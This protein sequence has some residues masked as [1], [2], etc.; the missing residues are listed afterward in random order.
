MG[1]N[2]DPFSKKII[3]ILKKKFKFLSIYLSTHSK[4]KPNKKILNW[5][6]DLIICFRSHFILNAMFIKKAKIGAIN[7]HPGPPQ[8]RGIGCINFALNNLENYY[9]ATAHLIEKK[10]D[11]GKILNLKLFKISKNSTIDKI[12]KKTYEVQIKQFNELITKLIKENYDFKKFNQ[13][14]S[15][16]SKLY[17]RKD[18][19]K[20][21]K[22]DKHINKKELIKRVRAT[23]T[24]K[25]KPYIM[26]HGYKFVLNI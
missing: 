24:K 18:L 26:V 25:Y 12:L 21:Y 22:I 3:N 17:L 1:R 19:E 2:N 23:N 6:G 4:D 7:F 8:Y 15:W 20:L 11:S 13:K 9:G 16:S 14:Y 5:K 10:V